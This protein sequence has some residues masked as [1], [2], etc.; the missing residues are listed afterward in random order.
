MVID[1]GSDVAEDR[2]KMIKTD[3]RN[4]MIQLKIENKG[5]AS[6]MPRSLAPAAR[7][8]RLSMRGARS[9]RVI[10]RFTAQAQ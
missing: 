9:T 5:G 1:V 8:R 3:H 10:Q 7:C 4:R 6:I 2:V